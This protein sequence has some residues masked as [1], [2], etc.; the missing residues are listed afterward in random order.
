MRGS[1]ES[2]K[3]TETGFK[4]LKEIISKLSEAISKGVKTYRGLST[5][6]YLDGLL[7][8]PNIP[9]DS[10]VDELQGIINCI[11]NPKGRADAQEAL[12]ALIGAGEQAKD[13]IDD[14]IIWAQTSGDGLGPQGRKAF[15]NAMEQSKKSLN[16]PY[17]M[18][19]NKQVYDLAMRS[20]INE[21]H[22]A[23]NVTLYSSGDNY[24][25]VFP[26]ALND[27]MQEISFLSQISM[28]NVVHGVNR[29]RLG[30]LSRLY[31]D[32]PNKAGLL[33][34]NHV[35][36][37][38]AKQVQLDAR[39]SAFPFVIQEENSKD[40]NA[41]KTYQVICQSGGTKAEKEKNYSKAVYALTKA[42]I[43]L[44]SPA[45]DAKCKKLNFLQKKS[46]ELSDGID[47]V[48]SG[49]ENK[50]YVF[51]VPRDCSTKGKDMIHPSEN[52]DVTERW[53][54]GAEETKHYFAHQ[55]KA[56]RQHVDTYRARQ[57]KNAYRDTMEISASS[58][59]AGIPIFVS[60]Q[61]MNDIQ[62]KA[63]TI[64]DNV[65]SRLETGINPLDLRTQLGNEAEAL[66]QQMRNVK[67][68]Q[69]ALKEEIQEKKTE[70]ELIDAVIQGNQMTE[71]LAEN[72]TL[73][74]QLY[75][76]GHFETMVPEKERLAD[77]AI[78]KMTDT[79]LPKRKASRSYKLPSM[80]M[81]PS[82]EDPENY[83]S[84]L[85]NA[86]APFESLTSKGHINYNSIEYAK[87]RNEMRSRLLDAGKSADSI[88][89]METILEGGDPTMKSYQEI[90]ADAED[91]LE[92]VT[93]CDQ[94]LNLSLLTRDLNK[95]NTF[96]HTIQQAR[97]QREEVLE[98][99]VDEREKNGSIVA[100]DITPTALSHK[101]EK[102]SLIKENKNVNDHQPDRGRRIGGISV[103]ER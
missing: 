21:C 91:K 11:G 51:Y 15:I 79:I 54:L 92:N 78:Q 36:E 17:Y 18:F 8:N 35:P 62:E 50:G 20:L 33:T 37:D 97:L 83:S 76:K 22:I 45:A 87:Y 95:T 82:M 34:F 63:E 40:E 65:Q 31:S 58:S 93:V 64:Y 19:V 47:S 38:I 14:M 98:N 89:D 3:S 67:V 2:V 90:L 55:N 27:M 13:G 39:G 84:D 25:M 59:N 94:S 60:E 44:A 32:D 1:S 68:G 53:E 5:Q 9:F 72:V 96:S 100:K 66:F 41:P 85:K 12:E 88:R 57:F 71:K 10:K 101:E 16:A 102:S 70:I 43:E 26:A 49:N 48:F 103:Q 86:F 23:Q 4:V 52:I 24:M 46:D 7:N 56:E 28:S 6:K 77:Q 30:L 73:R 74:L 61:E 29:E 69:K 99:M 81:A 80:K 42:S 75:T